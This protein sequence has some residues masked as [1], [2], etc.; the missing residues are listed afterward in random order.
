TLNIN[1][2][3]TATQTGLVIIDFGADWCPPCQMMAPIIESAAV[4]FAGQIQFKK[5]DIDASPEIA[6]A[7]DIQ[8][9]PTFLVKKEGHLIDRFSGFVPAPVFKSHVVQYLK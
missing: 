2:F 9:I 8:G 1:N 5:V 6:Q 3:K 4:D 7:F